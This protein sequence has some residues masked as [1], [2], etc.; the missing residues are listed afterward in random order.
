MVLLPLPLVHAPV[1]ASKRQPGLVHYLCFRCPAL[2]QV[3][4][5][6]GGQTLTLTIENG[7][8]VP[9]AATPQLQYQ[10]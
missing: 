5:G 9:A 1:T 10:C 8:M 7:T 6:E 2:S 3:R 4:L